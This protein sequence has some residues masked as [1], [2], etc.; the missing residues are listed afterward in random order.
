MRCRIDESKARAVSDSTYPLGGGSRSS[1]VLLIVSSVLAIPSRV[2]VIWSRR[3]TTALRNS[4]SDDR[5]D[6]VKPKTIVMSVPTTVSASPRSPNVA[7][8]LQDH[9]GD[10]ERRTDHCQ[11]P[12]SVPIV[13]PTK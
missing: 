1:S 6:A 4:R 10:C 13:G 9:D 2:A 5:V 11:G 8:E 7:K 3:G 12:P